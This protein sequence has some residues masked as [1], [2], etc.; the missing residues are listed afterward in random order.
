MAKLY[1]GKLIDE[2]T[3]SYPSAVKCFQDDFEA[4]IQ[5]MAFPA[6]HHKHLLHYQYF[7]VRVPGTEMQNYDDSS[8]IH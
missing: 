5:H 8:A 1:A 4:C 3:D 2:Y 6:G 7:G